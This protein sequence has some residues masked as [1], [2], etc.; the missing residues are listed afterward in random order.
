M[1]VRKKDSGIEGTVEAPK[2]HE[3]R[4]H[5]WHELG[6]GAIKEPYDLNW[7]LPKQPAG[8]DAQQQKKGVQFH[9]LEEGGASH[10]VSIFDMPQNVQARGTYWRFLCYHQYLCDHECQR[11]CFASELRSRRYPPISTVSKRDVRVTQLSHEDKVQ[12]LCPPQSELF[13][14][15]DSGRQSFAPAVTICAGDAMMQQMLGGVLPRSVVTPFA[16]T[17]VYRQLLEAMQSLVNTAEIYRFHGAICPD[18]IFVNHVV[19]SPFGWLPT[20]GLSAPLQPEGHAVPEP[21][22]SLE[23]F[24]HD[25]R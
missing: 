3:S 24:G 8:S 18:N 21:P 1:Q 9:P 13:K 5:V 15:N 11:L 10:F 12:A 6:A 17:L 19:A 7:H 14:S 4:P 16:A 22:K 2:V 20:I 23:L 25:M